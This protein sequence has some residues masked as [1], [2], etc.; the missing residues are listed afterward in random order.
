ML[1]GKQ[2]K[3]EEKKKSFLARETEAKQYK[4]IINIQGRDSW[5]Q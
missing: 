2:E 1:Y 5:A 4:T 3:K